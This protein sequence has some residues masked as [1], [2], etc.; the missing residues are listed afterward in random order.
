MNCVS[1]SSDGRPPLGPH[2][3]MACSNNC[4]DTPVASQ[5]RL[6]FHFIELATHLAASTPPE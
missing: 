5:P 6:R 1:A 2:F 4:H 3:S